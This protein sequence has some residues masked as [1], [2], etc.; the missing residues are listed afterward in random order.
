M[1]IVN[2]FLC[3]F[4]DQKKFIFITLTIVLLCGFSYGLVK[5]HSFQ[6]YIQFFF[7]NLY[8]LNDEKYLNQYQLYLFQ[9]AFYILICTY[10]SSSYIGQLGILFLTFIKGIQFAFSLLYVLNIVQISFLIIIF[11]LIETLFEI[12]FIYSLNSMCM[13]LSFYV[14]LIS[15]Y[16]EQ[17]LNIKSTLNYRLNSL[18]ISL[19]I[20]SISLA[21]R[22]YIIPLF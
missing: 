3:R 4:I 19:I 7:Q 8:Y 11:I 2:A 9:N 10:F 12:L 21:F 5:Y 1:I 16:L 22:I 14:T 17:N 15:F 6:K 20:F 13:H 18:I